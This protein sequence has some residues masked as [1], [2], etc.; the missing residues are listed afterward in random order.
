MK[1]KNEYE[2]AIELI[3]ALEELA[4]LEIE[5]KSQRKTKKA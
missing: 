1:A 2:L 3:E 5:Q 4:I